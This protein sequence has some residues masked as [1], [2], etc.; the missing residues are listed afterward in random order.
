[1]NTLGE[2]YSSER[3]ALTLHAVVDEVERATAKHGPLAS[4]LE[5]QAVIE[6]EYDEFV[7]EVRH[8]TRAAATDEAIQ[9]AAMFIKWLLQFGEGIP[10]T[11]P[12][13]TVGGNIGDPYIPDTP[14]LVP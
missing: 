8:G 3:L 2:M 11:K 14:D 6:E 12:R 9:G 4:P 13:V 1:M 7:E 10:G 5:G